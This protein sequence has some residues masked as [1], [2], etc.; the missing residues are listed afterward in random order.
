METYKRSE[1]EAN[2]IAD[3]FVQDN[4]SHSVGGVV[5]GLHFQT[6]PKSQAK[7]VMV[8]KGKI[9]DVAV[10]VRKNSPTFGQWA[11]VSLSSANM[12]ML[13]IPAGF[14]HGF[15]VVSEEVD[16]TYKVSAEYDQNLDRGIIWNDPAIGVSWPNS[17]PMLSDKDLKL[18][19]LA[20]ADLD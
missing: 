7:L 4:Y 12:N 16:F 15:C 17:N 11:G 6:S 2:G 1:F 5:R 19:N 14:A 20:D 18:P 10:D 13:Y 8:S 3:H 9:F